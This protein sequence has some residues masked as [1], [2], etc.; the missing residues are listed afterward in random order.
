MKT[1][2]DYLDTAN[3]CQRM[4]SKA[5]TEQEKISWLQLAEGW[6]RLLSWKPRSEEAFNT[7]VEQK[8]TGQ[9]KSRAS[10]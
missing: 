6:L 10:H 7:E 4:A 1:A 3:Q 2:D 9:E 5:K 8:G